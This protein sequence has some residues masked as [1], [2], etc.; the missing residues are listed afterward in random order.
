MVDVLN[1][2]IPDLRSDEFR[3]LF[4]NRNV[5]AIITDERYA[6]YMRREQ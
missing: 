5:P 4:D 2:G 3:L 1:D 6:I